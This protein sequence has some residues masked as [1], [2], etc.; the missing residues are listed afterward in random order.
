MNVIVDVLKM[1]IMS[2]SISGKTYREPLLYDD[3]LRVYVKAKDLDLGDLVDAA[4]NATLSVDITRVPDP[5]SDL[6]SMPA[7]YLW[8]LLDIRKE[9]VN[10]LVNN[11]GSWFYIGSMD[12]QYQFTRND[13]LLAFP[14]SRCR[15][16]N[17][18]REFQKTIPIWILDSI[19]ENPCPRTIRKIDFQ[20][21]LGC[22]R[23]GAAATAHFNRVCKKY[24]E[25]FGMF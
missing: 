5:C 2:R 6:V 15:C 16:V 12:S 25:E 19:K 3:P 8:Q 1:Q 20:V 18:E 7:I 4:V 14:P 21:Q 17:D 9:R 13:D 11:C 23:C 24:E 22:L 10:W